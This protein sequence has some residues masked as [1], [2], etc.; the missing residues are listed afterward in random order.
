GRA[1]VS[2][3][4]RVVCKS[5]LCSVMRARDGWD[6]RSL[7]RLDMYDVPAPRTAS[8]PV[9]L[10]VP[11]AALWLAVTALIALPVYYFIGVGR[12]AGALRGHNLFI[13]EFVQDARHFLGF[14]CH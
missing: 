5:D 1:T 13:P 12:G 9:V 14:P 7:R 10:P 4:P 8:T 3:P 2:R 6:A 11:K